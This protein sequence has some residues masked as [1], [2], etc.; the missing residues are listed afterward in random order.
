MELSNIVMLDEGIQSRFCHCVNHV[1]SLF[2]V[3]DKPATPA[4]VKGVMPF[5]GVLAIQSRRHE[6]KRSGW[7]ACRLWPPSRV[8]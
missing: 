3:G 1:H 7:L 2:L 6:A 5:Y 4:R 8:K